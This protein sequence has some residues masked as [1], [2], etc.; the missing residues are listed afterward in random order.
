LLLRPISGL[1]IVIYWA[2]RIGY[3]PRKS[4]VEEVALFCSQQ[5]I[6]QKVGLSTAS[7]HRAGRNDR[8]L[9][10]RE[11]NLPF[12]ISLRKDDTCAFTRSRVKV[13]LCAVTTSKLKAPKRRISTFTKLPMMLT[14]ISQLRYEKGERKENNGREAGI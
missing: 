14:T 11:L 9:I 6:F 7:S 8:G 1:L 5:M 10:S 4:E 3:P 12:W 13:A 2:L